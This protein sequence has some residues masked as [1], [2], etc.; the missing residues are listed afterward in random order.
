MY[1]IYL[2]ENLVNSKKYVGKT[3][4]NI[5]DRFW[6]HCH[7]NKTCIGKAI[8]KYG[9][10]NFSVKLL[11]QVYDKIE[12]INREKYY[13]DTFCS[14]YPSGYNIMRGQ[15]LAGGN[16]RMKGK[17]LPKSWRNNCSR[18]GIK[19]G[20]ACIYQ[21]HW[22]DTNEF[23]DVLM[24]KGISSYLNISLSTVKK[25]LNREHI[26]YNTKRPVKFYKK[27]RINNGKKL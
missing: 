14:I 1:K 18:P 11:E 17:H 6:E 15:S 5:N 7:N 26:D 16:N 3:K 12:A 27:E 2:I 20:K 24:W 22:L 10:E 8:N 13:T 21:I 9:K 23:I 25:W 19:N 4:R